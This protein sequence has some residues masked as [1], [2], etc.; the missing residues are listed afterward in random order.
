MTTSLGRYFGLAIFAFDLFAAQAALAQNAIDAFNVTQQ[1]GQVIVRM[2]FK[3]A[4][5]GRR[6]GLSDEGEQLRRVQ[7]QLRFEV[8]RP[9]GL[10]PPLAYAVSAGL[11]E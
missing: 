6:L 8:A 1:G 7:T 11:D 2:G 10:R 4:L 9:L 5:P 3:E